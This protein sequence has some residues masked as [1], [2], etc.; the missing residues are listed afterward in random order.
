MHARTSTVLLVGALLSAGAASRAVAQDAPHMVDP[1]RSSVHFSGADGVRLTGD[2]HV[3]SEPSGAAVVLIH[4]EGEDRTVF[5]DFADR[6]AR[7]KVVAFNIDLRGHGESRYRPT[8]S[9]AGVVVSVAR[10]NYKRQDFTLKDWQQLP[11]DVRAALAFLQKDRRARTGRIAVIGSGLGANAGFAASAT[12][13]AVQVAVALSPLREGRGLALED[14]ASRLRGRWL[15]VAASQG[16]RLGYEGAGLVVNAGGNQVQFAF[17]AGTA[18]G[19]ELLRVNPT[20]ADQ[21]FWWVLERLDVELPERHP[22]VM[23][24]RK[25]R[26]EFP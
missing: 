22:E 14:A 13:Q 1:V 16:D 24:R 18:R 7:A 15:F 8:S 5:R 6:L 23:A 3:P 26:G 25:A 2:L 19:V 10:A 12:G 11:D 20:L 21:L 9:D 17:P 4:D